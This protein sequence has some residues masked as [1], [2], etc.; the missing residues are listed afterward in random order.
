MKIYQTIEQGTD[1]WR[2]LRAGKITASRAKDA[3]DYKAL[4]KAQEKEGFGLLK[5]LVRVSM[6]LFL[7]NSVYVY[8]CVCVY[9]FICVYI[10]STKRRK[11]KA[12]GC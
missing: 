1:E 5:N 7:Y 2:S 4:T 11:K 9:V 6:Y 10:S 12:L 8:V 3:R